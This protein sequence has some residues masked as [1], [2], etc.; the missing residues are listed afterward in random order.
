MGAASDSEGLASIL[1]RSQALV[2]AL[3]ADL[4]GTTRIGADDDRLQLAIDRL[5]NS[6]VRPLASASGGAA[7]DARDAPEGSTD[8][9]QLLGPVLWR[10]ALDVTKLS[11]AKG[12][13]SAIKEA[14]AA[15]QDLACRLAVG[16]GDN[17]LS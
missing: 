11:C 4:G 3:R 15:L 14:A 17:G 1:I 12:A 6:V 16:D 8:R 7:A 5:T 10:L 9:S 13:S 2:D